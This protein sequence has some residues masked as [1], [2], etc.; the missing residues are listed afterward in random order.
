MFED[1]VAAKGVVCFSRAAPAARFFIF[2]GGMG[3]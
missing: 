1:C 2:E 3:G